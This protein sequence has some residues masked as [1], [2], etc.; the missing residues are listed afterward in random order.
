MLSRLLHVHHPTANQAVNT[1]INLQGLYIYVKY[2][3][4]MSSAAGLQLFFLL[5]FSH[6]SCI[7][8]IG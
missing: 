2:G 7:E 8:N 3:F 1:A 4:L 5:F 6:I